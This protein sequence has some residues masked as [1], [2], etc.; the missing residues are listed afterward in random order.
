MTTELFLG[1]L[2]ILTLAAVII[3]ALTTGRR[4][5]HTDEDRAGSDER[6]PEA[7]RSNYRSDY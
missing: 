4:E 5:L 3:L 7:Q 2:T 6:Q 1:G